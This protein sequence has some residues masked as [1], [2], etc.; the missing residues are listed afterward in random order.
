MFFANVKDTGIDFA[1]A[2]ILKFQVKSIFEMK[3][4]VVQV[5]LQLAATLRIFCIRLFAPEVL[6]IISYLF[7]YKL[8][9]C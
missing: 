6:F 2:I 4:L 5:D 1:D 7:R 9:P 3:K 8:L